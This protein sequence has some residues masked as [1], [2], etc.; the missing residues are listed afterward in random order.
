[1]TKYMYSET[2]LKQPLKKDKK[3]KGFKAMWYLNA[4]QKYCKHFAILL[5]CI[6]QLSTS[7]TYFLVFFW[8]RIY[9]NTEILLGV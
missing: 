4:G 9:C 5:T 1:M 7:K 2:C 3:N 8:D 6:K